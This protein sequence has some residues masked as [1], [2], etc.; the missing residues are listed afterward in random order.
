MCRGRIFQGLKGMTGCILYVNPTSIHGGAEEALLH[1]MTIAQEL[2]Y[3]PVLVVP[4]SGWLT[5]RCRAEGIPCELLSSLP[6]AVTS[7][8]WRY[9]LRPWP[10]NAIA[11]AQF[12]RKWSAV[13]VHS[14][15]PRTAYHGGLGARLSGVKAVTH[16]HDIVQLPYAV[17]PKAWLLFQLTD[18]T[19]VASQAVERAVIE[20]APRFR[21]CTQ[22]VY[23]GWERSMYDQ[24]PI[25]DI[26]TLFQVP[27]TSVIIGTVAAMTPWK[28]QDVLIE[29]FRL[30]RLQVPHVH[31]VIVGGS[32]GGKRQ[33]AY[34]AQLH[35][36][37]I[38]A[39]LY[40]AV[41]FTGWRED[42]WALIKGFDIF[43]HVPTA[44]DPL[45]TAL[46]HAC[47]LGSAI[48]AADTG[49]I[50]EIV[51]N[52]KSGL[53][54]PPANPQALCDAL[55]RLITNPAYRAELGRQA[56]A[57]FNRHFSRQQMKEGIASAY[58]QCLKQ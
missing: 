17:P 18:W 9:Q 51:L 53:L 56:I 16:V 7:D 34:E 35:Q 14:N 47:A 32:Q 11:I 44:P 49:G 6:D 21:S 55:N 10:L 20:L 3:Q 54:V 41:T 50:P 52:D 4:M 36:Q 57:H 45:P 5:D 28:G 22:V 33:S 37:V 40:D 12:V 1:N 13:L 19:L 8:H 27:H 43:V 25:A 29:A 48:V 58:H 30:L 15:T 38:D 42:V 24:V 26:R 23:Y 39:G 31:L 2:G 46:L